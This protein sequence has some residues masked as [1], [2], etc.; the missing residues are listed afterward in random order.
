M[1]K[2]LRQFTTGVLVIAYVCIIMAGIA[3]LFGKLVWVMDTVNLSIGTVLLTILAIVLVYLIG[4]GAL[5]LE[6]KS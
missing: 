3:V 6:E 2:I 1:R 4:V 5:F